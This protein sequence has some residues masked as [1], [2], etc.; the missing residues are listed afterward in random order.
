MGLEMPQ[1]K[2]IFSVLI[3]ILDFAIFVK[4]TAKATRIFSGIAIPVVNHYS[5]Q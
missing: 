5:P 3:Q 2:D 1:E 4:I